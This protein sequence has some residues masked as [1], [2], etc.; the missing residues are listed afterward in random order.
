[1]PRTRP[2]KR[3]TRPKTREAVLRDYIAK[4]L[5]ELEA[6]LTLIQKEYP[7]PV[8]PHGAGGS[9]DI[10]AE[11]GAGHFVVIEIKKTDHSARET[12]H[13]LSKYIT[14]L[15]EREGLGRAEIRCIVLSVEWRELLEPFSYFQAMADVQVQGFAVEEEPGQPIRYTPVVPR[16]VTDLPSFSPDFDLFVYETEAERRKH[17][18]WIRKR[19]KD[20]AGVKAAFVQLDR[21]DDS[22]PED[23]PFRSIVCMWRID[24]RDYDAV[25]AACNLTFG[26]LAP[27]AFPGWEP[28]ADVLYWLTCEGTPLGFPGTA[29]QQ[30]G[31]S[32]KVTN[33]LDRYAVADVVPLG[34]DARRRRTLSTPD[35]VL[36][37]LQGAQ[38]RTPAG[39]HHP[40]RLQERAT[41]ANPKSWAAAVDH[42]L[43]FLAPIPYWQELAE[44][45]LREIAELDPVPP[46]VE[47]EGF[48]KPHFFY[49]I[50]QARE[51]PE[52][53]LSWFSIA[54]RDASGGIGE[55]LIGAWAWDG[56]CP[57]SARD[58][59]IQVYGDL[60]VAAFAV[61]TAKGTVLHDGYA[62]HGFHPVGV[63]IPYSAGQPHQSTI[64]SQEWD[65]SEVG[66]VEPLQAFVAAHPDYA[67]DVSELL[68]AYGWIGTAP[69]GASP[70]LLVMPGG[71][72]DGV[73][74]GDDV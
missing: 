29:E 12:L 26:H 48:L 44:K 20:L 13:E 34:R 64:F 23:F 65:G 59:I 58:A 43:S 38:R 70:I 5:D 17:L 69:G 73:A 61:I 33:L 4:H 54:V 66:P 32:E 9:I 2:G 55:I 52:T 62:L 68:T 37:L 10:L 27:Y 22:P 15:R 50:H 30:R 3:Q 72:G 6:E 24:D 49:A 47:F 71:A 18:S 36:R 53:S 40:G 63:W 1:M 19:I 57:V 31:T 16:P 46:V 21:V 7:L 25:Q 8:S 45:Y 51:H 28:E 42:L 35:R 56:S 11:D 74:D 41:P 14:L 67:T 60:R 39:R